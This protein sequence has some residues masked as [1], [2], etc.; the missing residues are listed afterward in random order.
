MESEQNSVEQELDEFLQADRSETLV[1]ER[2]SA[3]RRQ[4][5][6]E[7]KRLLSAKQRRDDYLRVIADHAPLLGV[8]K[9]A[10]ASPIHVADP[11]T[12]VLVLSDIHVGQRTRVEA[13]GGI[14][15]QSTEITW[16]Q[17]KILWDKLVELYSYNPDITE[18]VILKLGDVVE[19]DGMRVSQ[20]HG[21]DSLV[22]QQTID[23]T[24][25][26]SWLYQQAM[27]LWPVKVYSV[28][29]NHDR[30]SQKAGNAGLG[31]NGYIDTFSWLQDAFLERLFTKSIV[32][33]RIS[34][35]NHDSFYGAAKIAGQRFVY[36]HGASFRTGSGSYG[37][38]S[39]Y[40]ISAAARSYMEMVDGADI[41]AF[42]HY[43]N[44]AVLPIKGGWGWQVLNGA[45]PPSTEWVQS[46][47]KKVGR[48]SQ[49][50]LKMHPRTGLV[51]WQPIYLETDHMIKP[52]DFWD[53]IDSD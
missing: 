42:G 27:T 1:R 18:L 47:F 19:G 24:D 15:E 38:V 14:Y 12:W 37:G 30:T 22:T 39:W 7:W 41:V 52:G 46:S 28:G 13:T 51:S 20:A 49:T 21:I 2:E 17:F 44:S 33:G 6:A 26:L 8:P 34:L 36:E 3:L 43:H 53:T 50:L 31:E 48:P 32:D 35:T 25:M 11:H 16:M 10:K 23:A 9:L 4:E 45:F 5:I 40:P 29:G